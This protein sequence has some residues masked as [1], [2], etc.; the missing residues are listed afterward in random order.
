[1]RLFIRILKFYQMF[2]AQSL[3]NCCASF[4]LRDLDHAVGGN[5][6]RGIGWT[7]LRCTR[8]IEFVKGLLMLRGAEDFGGR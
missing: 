7:L 8:I 1:M 2:L 3:Y 5:M 6:R 4:G